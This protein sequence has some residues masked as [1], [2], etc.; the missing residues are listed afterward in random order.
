M[1]FN[2]TKTFRLLLVHITSRTYEIRINTILRG[3]VFIDHSKVPMPASVRSVLIANN[4][5]P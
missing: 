3:L 5:G 2:D 4:C 1:S